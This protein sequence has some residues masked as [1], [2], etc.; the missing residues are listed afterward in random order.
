M[1]NEIS[2]Y[3]KYAHLQIAAEAFYGLKMRPAGTN[4]NRQIETRDLIKGNDRTSKFT[5]TDAEWFVQTW[6][7]EEH[8]SNTQTGFS[9]TLFRALK[10]DPERG[11]VAGELVLSFRSTEFADDA[12]RDN[13]ATNKMEISEKG[14]AFGQIADMEKWY[15]SLKASGKIG[16][17]EPI[18]VTGYSLGGHLATAFNLLHKDDLTAMGAPVISATYTFNGAGV[19]KIKQGSLAEVMQVFS[20][21]RANGASSRMLSAHG[22][23][24]YA[25]LRAQFSSFSDADTAK[26]SMNAAIRV[27]SRRKWNW[28]KVKSNGV[29][30]RLS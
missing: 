20:D 2:N 19:G 16:V 13:Q 1:T 29:E 26:T 23:S 4:L 3:L 27:C 22:Q 5:T 30:Q 25:A 17:S 9:G 18:A 10:D 6:K 12:A 11:I 24:T 7:V 21:V 14:W 28:T 8:I 15:A